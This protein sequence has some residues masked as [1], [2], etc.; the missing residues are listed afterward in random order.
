MARICLRNRA[1]GRQLFADRKLIIGKTVLRKY[2]GYAILHAHV[3]MQI[4]AE[5]LDLTIGM[6][7]SA[8]KYRDALVLDRMEPSKSIVD[9]TIPKQ[10]QDVESMRVILPSPLRDFAD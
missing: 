7:H 5:G 1:E 9:S 4:I 3:K 2:C 8:E 10:I 6:S